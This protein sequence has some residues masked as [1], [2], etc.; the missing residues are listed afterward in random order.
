MSDLDSALAMLNAQIANGT[1]SGEIPAGDYNVVLVTVSPHAN[2]NSIRLDADI[3]YGPFKGR[4]IITLVGTTLSA[5][6]NG[7][8]KA[9]LDATKVEPSDLRALLEMNELALHP[10]V[11]KT[12]RVKR[13][14]ASDGRPNHKIIGPAT[15]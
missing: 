9:F 14:I 1:A 7:H 10:F 4:R 5:V 15:V 11:G 12:M 2:G 6:R 8:V 13:L 3:T